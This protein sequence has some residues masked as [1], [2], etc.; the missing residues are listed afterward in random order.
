[1]LIMLIDRLAQ[2]IFGACMDDM[3]HVEAPAT[4]PAFLHPPPLL[5]DNRLILKA[6][7]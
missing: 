4:P 7:S 5:L 1:M 2:K 6:A 3:N